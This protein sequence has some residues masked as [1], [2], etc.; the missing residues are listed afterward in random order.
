MTLS[1]TARVSL[2]LLLSACAAHKPAQV[3]ERSPNISRAQ[4]IPA[5]GSAS[6]ASFVKSE[7]TVPVLPHPAVM[8]QPH[9]S[10]LV[11]KSPPPAQPKAGPVIVEVKPIPIAPEPVV[12]ALD[13]EPEDVNVPTFSQPL[14]LKVPYSEE[15]YLAGFDSGAGIANPILWEG[16]KWIWPT[17]GAVVTAFGYQGSKGI[18]IGGRTGGPV[19][20]VASGK[21][22]YVGEGLPGYGKLVIIRHDHRFISA[23]GNN[24]QIH[25]KEG[26]QVELGEKISSMGQDGHGRAVLILEVRRN[27]TPIDPTGFMSPVPKR[28]D[29]KP[30][31][32]R[33]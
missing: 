28:G 3:V 25:V 1:T 15:A 16:V 8:E 10:D 26:Q 29:G 23:Y 11:I 19:A 31:S 30:D 33:G 32:G 17:A 7:A 18:E 12:R 14:G 22:V 27:G 4:S 5:A 20:A 2:V 13:E 6:R 9:T 24:Q 21:V